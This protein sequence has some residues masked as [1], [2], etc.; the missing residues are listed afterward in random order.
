MAVVAAVVAAI[1]A[2]VVV[3][4]AT[5]VQKNSDLAHLDRATGL[6]DSSRSSKV[7]V[8]FAGGDCDCAD[9]RAE[10][11]VVVVA[12]ADPLDCNN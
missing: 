1:V 6:A 8:S 3:A 4:V 10:E 2:V 5:V 9:L 7:L 12:V 11:A